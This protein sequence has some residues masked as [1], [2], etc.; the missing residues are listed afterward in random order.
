MTNS[1]KEQQIVFDPFIGSGTTAVACVNT[2]RNFIGFELSEE[3]CDI[4]NARI[5]SVCP[6]VELAS[7]SEESK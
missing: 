2:G 5:A 6:P 4:A 3:Y 1:S 7:E